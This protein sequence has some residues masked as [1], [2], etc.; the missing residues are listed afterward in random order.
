MTVFPNTIAVLK[1]IYGV[2]FEVLKKCNVEGV[3]CRMVY[4]ICIAKIHQIRDVSEKTMLTPNEFDVID[5]NIILSDCDRLNNFTSIWKSISKAKHG[6][7]TMEP[8][9]N[10]FKKKN[11]LR[12]WFNAANLSFKLFKRTINEVNWKFERA[13]WVK[14]KQVRRIGVP[15]LN[16]SKGID[17]IN[18]AVQ[19]INTNLNFFS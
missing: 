13:L 8:K 6:T 17:G 5:R 2:E 19:H 18:I 16:S 3:R 14:A 10:F 11:Y 4:Q 9:L 15:E 7:K 1:I 12:C